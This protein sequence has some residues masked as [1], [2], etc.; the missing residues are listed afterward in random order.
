EAWL[1]YVQENY[2][3]PDGLKHR[4]YCGLFFEIFEC[5]RRRSFAPPDRLRPALIRADRYLHE[6]LRLLAIPR[7][8]YMA[9]LENPIP[10]DTVVLKSRAGIQLAPAAGATDRMKAVTQALYKL[11]HITKR[12]VHFFR[13]RAL[14]LRATLLEGS[15]LEVLPN[16][17][18]GGR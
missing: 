6:S 2:P 5:D 16:K 15:R 10:L 7:A 4:A 12:S 8:E 3:L 9:P 14:V 18:T 1:A 17:S 13:R 11:G